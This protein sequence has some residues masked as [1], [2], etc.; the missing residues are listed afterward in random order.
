[1]ARFVPSV[2]RPLVS[3]LPVKL[4]EKSSARYARTSSYSDTAW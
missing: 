4:T 1:M 3:T 2:G